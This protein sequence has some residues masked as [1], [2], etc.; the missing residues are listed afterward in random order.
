M[1]LPDKGSP[2][3]KG[4]PNFDKKFNIEE[5]QKD[6]DHIVSISETVAMQQ[7]ES[8][9]TSEPSCEQWSLLGLK[10]F[11]VPNDMHTVFNILQSPIL[12][13]KTV[14]ADFEANASALRPYMYARNVSGNAARSETCKAELKEW[15]Q[16]MPA[17]PKQPKQ[18]RKSNK[19]IENELEP[20][21]VKAKRFVGFPKG[22][23]A[24]HF[25]VNH[26]HVL[27]RVLAKSVNVKRQPT[28][29]YAT[30]NILKTDREMIDSLDAIPVFS[31]INN[32]SNVGKLCYNEI[33]I[34]ILYVLL[35]FSNY[36]LFI[37]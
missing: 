36:C 32:S 1:F 8:Q 6:V 37:R 25:G 21:N 10:G 15:L 24:E 35:L 16:S 12:N 33:F 23:A 30:A 26:V 29:A 27:E 19:D 31:N 4:F 9:S 2:W 20:E 14:A 18:P 5:F 3:C 13:K 22:A 34:M 17:E 28:S 7:A 11:K